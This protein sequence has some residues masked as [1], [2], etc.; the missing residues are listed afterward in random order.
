[1][2][3]FTLIILLIL[4]G[5]SLFASPGGA[6]YASEDVSGRINNEEITA[7]WEHESDAEL[8][9]ER[10]LSDLRNMRQ[11][12]LVINSSCSYKSIEKM[13]SLRK[14]AAEVISSSLK[15][16]S[17]NTEAYAA[18]V[19]LKQMEGVSLTP[20][21]SS[22]KRLVLSA[23]SLFLSCSSHENAGVTSGGSAP[24]SDYGI[25]TPSA[26]SV[27]NHRFKPGISAISNNRVN[28]C[29]RKITCAGGRY[30]IELADLYRLFFYVRDNSGN[31]KPGSYTCYTSPSRSIRS[32]IN[33]IQYTSSEQTTFIITPQGA[34][35]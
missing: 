31:G 14:L 21:S 27:I 18:A 4:Q 9:G 19:I 35:S 29:P 17:V 26:V 15:H 2:R 23:D 13:I 16:E 8:L 5:I 7:R 32:P 3:I 10:V 24:P 20:L 6:L 25:F 28:I 1:M 34:F 12:G 11:N 22:E 30:D 33:S